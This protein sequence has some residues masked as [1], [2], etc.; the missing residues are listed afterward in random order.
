MPITRE[1]LESRSRAAVRLATTDVGS[2]VWT[3]D[4]FWCCVEDD[5]TAFT[6][7]LVRDG[8]WEAWVT[9]WAQRQLRESDLFVDVGANVGYYSLMAAS[10]GCFVLSFEPNVGLHQ[11]INRAAAASGLEDAIDL[12]SAALGERAG[13]AQLFVP[14][15]HSGAGSLVAHSED[16]AETLAVS[17]VGLDEFVAENPR[18]GRPRLIKVDAEGAEPAIWRGAQR[19]LSQSPE[20]IVLLEWDPSRYTD[21]KEQVTT[22]RAT[23]DIT[24][25]DGGGQE[26][27]ASDDWLGGCGMEMIVLRSLRRTS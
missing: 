2:A 12:R 24:R 26:W 16:A 4:R 5:D 23:H 21:W 1:E 14:Q 17:V 13:T 27:P 15:G 6:P 9:V 22:F 11:Y 18:Y 8:F 19:L 25:I 3:L 20:T 7:N 10:L